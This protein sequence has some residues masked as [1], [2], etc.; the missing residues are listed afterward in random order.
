M[1]VK[2]DFGLAPDV[3]PFYSHVQAGVETECRKHDISLM[4]ANIEVD[5]ANRPV[6]WPPM[7]TEQ[8]VDG[9]LLVG[10]FI[11]DTASILRSRLDL[12]IVLVNGYAPRLPFDSVVI[13]NRGGTKA[14]IE[15][16]I[17]K[18]HRHIGLLG[19]NPASPPSVMERR[20]A[21]VDTL[22]EHGLPERYIEES[23]LSQQSGYA[24]LQRLVRRAPEVTAFFA[25]ADIV[26]IA[27]LNAARDL[28]I[29]VP[30]QLSVVGFDNIDMSTVVTPALTTVHVHKTWMGALGVRQLLH[31]SEEPQQPKLTISVATQLVE[32]DSVAPPSAATARPRDLQ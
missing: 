21:F 24:A 1:L 22:R 17:A 4:Y 3:N 6:I 23:E 11:E 29:D 32:R 9:L 5:A 8:R 31:R 30:G 13:E 25:C 26:A 12:P 14:A 27:A 28:G 10:T 20:L 18:G 2:H 16:L 7:L 15:H 19:T